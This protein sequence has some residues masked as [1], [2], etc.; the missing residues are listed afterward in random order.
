MN[1]DYKSVFFWAGQLISIYV[2]S[3]ISELVLCV[4]ISYRG[5]LFRET[6]AAVEPSPIP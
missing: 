5:I 2:L 6:A 1:G 4:T 3:P